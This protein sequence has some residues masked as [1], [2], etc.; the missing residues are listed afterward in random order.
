MPYYYGLHYS[1]EAIAD[2]GIGPITAEQPARTVDTINYLRSKYGLAPLKMEDLKNKIDVS[3]PPKLPAQGV[4][5]HFILRDDGILDFAPPSDIDE[6]G[7]NIARLRSLHPTLRELARE[8]LELLA[9]GNKPHADLLDRA[10][11]YTTLVDQELEAISFPILF[12]EGVRIQNATN[13]AE[14]KIA[15]GEL[16]PF[17]TGVDEALTSLIHLHGAFILSTAAGIELMAAEERYR[18][19]PED[20][21]E[22]RQASVALAQEMIRHPDL[23]NP[24]VADFVASVADEIDRGDIP[25]RSS[26]IGS[27][28]VRNASIVFVA[29]A[30]VAALPVAG[31]LAIGIPGAIIGGLLALIGAEGLKKTKSFSHVSSAVTKTLDK[32]SDADL[33][34]RAA[35]LRPYLKFVLSAEEPLRRIAGTR[36]QFQ[37]LHASLDWLKATRKN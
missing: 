32:I 3:A 6:E 34:E 10:K 8:A 25:E 12:A 2:E 30:S 21:R 36:S 19:K 27:G 29:A 28:T 33:E 7:N 11:K 5:P 26:V 15:E 24:E 13:A 35:Q 23:V 22:L 14:T 20:E 1:K 37:W 9:R 31:T 4:G 18:R 17:E 16:P